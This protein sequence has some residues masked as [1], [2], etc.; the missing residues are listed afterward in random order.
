MMDLSKA[1][2]VTVKGNDMFLDALSLLPPP[3][4]RGR[5]TTVRVAGNQLVQTIGPASDSTLPQLTLDPAAKNYMLYRG[6]TLHFGKL[7]M[8]DAEMLVVD[9]DPTSPFDFDN[10]NYRAQLVA[11]HSKTLADMGL[12][13][14]MPDASSLSA[15][16]AMATR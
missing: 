1:T 11:G 5:L 14:W 2:G 9:A 6:G 15:P 8:T 12:E 10:A 4:I 3:H 13:V 16:R 7:F